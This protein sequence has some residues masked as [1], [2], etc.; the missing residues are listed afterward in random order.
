MDFICYTFYVAMLLVSLR[1]RLQHVRYR[2]N[3]LFKLNYQILSTL[4][5]Q[6]QSLL[7]APSGFTHE[8][9]IVRPHR[10]LMYFA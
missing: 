4:T 5:F 10:V 1:L 2:M 9:P 3:R 6:A 7:Y 8:K